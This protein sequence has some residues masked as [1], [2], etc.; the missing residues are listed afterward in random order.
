MLNLTAKC[1]N[2]MN[3]RP[4]QGEVGPLCEHGR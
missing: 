2:L 3:I 1:F 4:V